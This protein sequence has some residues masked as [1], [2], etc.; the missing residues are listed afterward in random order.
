MRWKKYDDETAVRDAVAE[1][2]PA[3]STLDDVQRFAT[4]EGL[5]CSGLVDGVVRC[6]APAPRH[7]LMVRAKW[8]IELHFDGD[9]LSEV[10]VERGLI[11][12]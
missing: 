4:A 9:T 1:R 3:G 10:R 6:S 5:E 8:L 7:S 2:L 12:P 11:G